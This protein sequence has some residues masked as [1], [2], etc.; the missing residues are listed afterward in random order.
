MIYII[1]KGRGKQNKKN[2]LCNYAN[3]RCMYY[4]LYN[5]IMQQSVLLKL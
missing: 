3:I 1:I 4:Q 2:K 5:K